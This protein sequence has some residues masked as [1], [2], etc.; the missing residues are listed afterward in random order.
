MGVRLNTYSDSVGTGRVQPQPNLTRPSS[1]LI[2]RQGAVQKHTTVN[3]AALHSK[4]RRLSRTR[5]GVPFFVDL[6]LGRM[7]QIINRSE[8]M[9][10]LNALAALA[11]L[12]PFSNEED[13]RGPKSRSG[14]PRPFSWVR[15]IWRMTTP[16]SMSAQ[17]TPGRR[18]HSSRPGCSL[19]PNANDSGTWVPRIRIC[20]YSG[21]SVRRALP[22]RRGGLAAARRKE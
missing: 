17:Q 11:D 19:W 5:S 18:S 22:V 2:Q 3:P 6:A 21:P 4:E 14:L 9:T 15:V 1:S 7:L 20:G 10:A 12:L 8:A 13:R 16:E